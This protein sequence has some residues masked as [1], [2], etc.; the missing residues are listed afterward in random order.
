MTYLRAT[1][2]T[3]MT[4]GNLFCGFLSVWYA[5]KPDDSGY[6]AAA[7]L[8]M[9]AAV[10]DALDGMIARL[11]KA[12][13]QFGVELDSLADVC[14]F[15]MAPAILLH[16]Y[17]QLPGHLGLALA[18]LFFACG[19]LRL[20][21]FNTQLKGF[22]KAE[23]KGLPIPAA[24]GTIASLVIFDSK[25]FGGDANVISLFA[26]LTVLTALLMV[27]KVRYDTRGTLKEAK[28]DR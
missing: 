12:Q 28:S 21:R 14:S 4:L 16:Q 23:F 6:I 9:A 26:P 24:A 10:F 15:G 11:I 2:P 17:Y 13:S 25:A 27:S 20:A 19:A 7:W 3:L 5:V 22:D 18:F 8:I 1:M